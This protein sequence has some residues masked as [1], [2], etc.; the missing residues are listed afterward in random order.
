LPLN[1]AIRT[2]PS[3]IPKKYMQVVFSYYLHNL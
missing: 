2:K 1:F 3:Q